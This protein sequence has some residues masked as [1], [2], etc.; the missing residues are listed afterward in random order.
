MES[1]LYKLI[2]QVMREAEY[3]TT[4]TY[5]VKFLHENDKTYERT[6][7]PFCRLLW[8]YLNLNAPL[9]SHIVLYR[10][11][12]LTNDMI[13]SYR[14]VIGPDGQYCITFQSFSSTTK[15]RT[16]ALGFDNTLF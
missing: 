12:T 14:K 7:A 13:N 5:E 1:F 3:Y 10:G 6:L 4:D 16:K 9:V 8:D 11:A 2:N 15:N